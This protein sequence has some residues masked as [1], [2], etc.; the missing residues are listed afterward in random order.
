[1]VI[2]LRTAVLRIKKEL[3]VSEYKNRSYIVTR[4]RRVVDVLS[5]CLRLVTL[6]VTN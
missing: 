2:C 3:P 5:W 6:M 1:M 4:R